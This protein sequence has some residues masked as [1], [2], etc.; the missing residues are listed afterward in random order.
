MFARKVLRRIFEPK[1]DNVTGKKSGR[2]VPVI[3]REGP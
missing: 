2:T 3:G 1:R